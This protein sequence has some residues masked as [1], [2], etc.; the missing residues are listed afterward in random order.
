MK[1]TMAAG[2]IARTMIWEKADEN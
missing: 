2:I 1:S